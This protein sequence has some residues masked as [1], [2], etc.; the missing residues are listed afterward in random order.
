MAKFPKSPELDRDA[1]YEARASALKRST[2]E[3]EAEKNA[4]KFS[5]EE[6]NFYKEL[7]KKNKSRERWVAPLLLILT[8]L[9]SFAIF[10]L[11][12]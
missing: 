11:N 8:V 6:K 5:R 4:R 7:E 10:F 2:E 1:D 12:T 9:V 3:I